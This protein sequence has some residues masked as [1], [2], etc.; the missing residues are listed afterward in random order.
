MKKPSI[1]A[2]AAIFV[3]SASLAFAGPWGRGMGPGGGYG[4]GPGGGGYGMG[5]GGGGYGMG[6]GMG[7]SSIPNLTPEQTSKI[8]ALQKAHLD[9]IAP[10][11]QELI[12]KSAELRSLWLNPTPDSAAVSAKQKEILDLRAKLQESGTN[13]ALEFRKVLTPEQQAQVAAFGP[14]MGRGMGGGYGVGGGYGMGRGHGMGRMGY[15]GRW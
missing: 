14:G 13:Y 11:Q 3:L 4:M 12:K 9:E 7:Y 10:I 15:G 1:V 5:Q 8:Q 2:V 6:P